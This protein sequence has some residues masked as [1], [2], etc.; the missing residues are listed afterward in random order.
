M[1]NR[2]FFFCWCF[3]IFAW[4]TAAA[5]GAAIT[6]SVAKDWVPA[7]AN[8]AIIRVTL[9]SDAADNSAVSFAT[10][11]SAWALTPSAVPTPAAASRLHL[12]AAPQHPS[13]TYLFANRANAPTEPCCQKTTTR[14]TLEEDAVCCQEK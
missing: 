11:C 9:P 6:L 14:D 1:S 13:L 7:Q 8:H 2:S 5:Q 10:R 12:A 4:L 3:L